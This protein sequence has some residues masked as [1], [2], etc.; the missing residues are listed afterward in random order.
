MKKLSL[1]IG[2]AV[3]SSF[4]FSQNTSVIDDAGIGIKTFNAKQAYMAGE[5]NKALKLY[6]EA[7]TAKPNDASILF[8]VG[9][10]YYVLQQINE[11]LTYLQKSETIDSNA[12]EDL[13]LVLGMVYQQTDQVDRALAEFNLHKKKNANSPQKL[14]IDDINHLIAEC[15]LAKQMESHPVNVKVKNAGD[16]INSEFDDKSPSVTADGTTLIFTSS[17]PLAVGNMKPIQDPTA[18]FDNVYICQWDSAKNDWGL[19]YPIDGDVNEAYAHTSCTSISPDGNYIFLYKNNIHGAS[20]GGDI[21]ISK[22]TMN[23]KWGKPVSVGKNINTSYYEDGACLSPDGN[24]LYFTSER[25]GGY[26]R[27]DIYKADRI[28]RNEWGVPENLGPVVNSGYDEGAPFMAPDGRTLFFSSDGHASMG[29]YDIF[30]TYMNDSGKWATPENLGYPINTVNN[31]KGFTISAD[32][33]T[34]YFSSDRKGGLGKRDIYIVDLSGY[35]VLV[36]DSSDNKPKGYS[37]LRGKVSNVKGEA[38][39]DAHVTVSDSAGVKVATISTSADGVYFI[40][41]KSG[42]KYKIKASESGYKN[43]TKSITMPAE[44]SV[45]TFSM[46]QDFV[47]EKQ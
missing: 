10:C 40:T 4:A 6:T 30:K 47:L 46:Q 44:S 9:Q 20:R 35:S 24:T 29:G 38:I 27:A 41:V 21:Y 23:D 34:G 18:T 1:L 5:Y 32:A 15:I 25:P 19:S 2:L 7:N 14:E 11:A 3:V 12:N 43:S 22:R 36:N 33:R 42:K 26:G 16:A 28:S 13:H 39:T 45:G 8:H 31:E 37:I 17:R